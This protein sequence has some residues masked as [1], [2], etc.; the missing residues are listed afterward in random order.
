MGSTIK[1][2]A[3]ALPDRRLTNRELVEETGWSSE[4]IEQTTGIVARPVAGETEC[5]SDLAAAAAEALFGSTSLDPGTVDFLLFCTQTP[6]YILPATAC[7]LQHRLS[8][9]T[10]CGAFDINLGCSGY[11]Y[12][13]AVAHGLLESGLARNVL[14]LTG[15]T[16]VRIIHPRDRSA[17]VLFGDAASAT[18]IGATDDERIGPFVFGTDG[19]GA[20]NIILRAGGF[21]NPHSPQTAVEETDDSG[22]V[23]TP[24]NLLMKGPEVFAFSIRR[25]PEALDECLSRAGLGPAEIDL[26]VFHQ[27]SGFILEHL[28]RKLRIPEDKMVIRIRDTGNT[29]SS[30]V[31]LALLGAL[32]DGRLRSGSQVMLL[33]FGVGYSWAACLVRWAPEAN[34]D[35]L[36]RAS[37]AKHRASQSPA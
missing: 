28:R 3:Q 18:W 6:D 36:G 33:G 34:D 5:A 20:Q 8:I 29:N 16:F 26:F 31:P 12:G 13:V 17:R 35:G 14:L 23:R 22:N 25:A 1:A 4:M 19:S 2:I 7:T 10:P 30:S 37:V 32:E 9:P 15:D 27:A 21:R 24:E 11:V